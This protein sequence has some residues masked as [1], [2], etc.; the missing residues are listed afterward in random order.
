MNRRPRVIFRRVRIARRDA[1]A[2]VTSDKSNDNNR[3]QST[4]SPRGIHRFIIINNHGNDVRRAIH[5][6]T[7]ENTTDL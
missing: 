6:F 4:S 2:S 7:V 1:P 5:A 3:M